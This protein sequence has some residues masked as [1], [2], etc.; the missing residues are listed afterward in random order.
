MSESIGITIIGEVLFDC[1]PDGKQIPGGAPFNVAWNLHAMGCRPKFISAVGTDALGRS[2][3]KLA[4]DWGIDTCGLQSL[5]DKETAMVDVTFLDGNPGFNIREDT[6][7]DHLTVPFLSEGDKEGILYHGSLVCRTRKIFETIGSLR[8]GWKGPVFVDINIR[9]PWFD[10][11]RFETLI[12]GV[13]YLK[14]NDSEYQELMGKAFSLEQ[15]H[16]CLEAF[17]QRYQIDNLIVTCGSSGSA[18]FDG[19]RVYRQQASDKLQ[20]SDTVGAGDTFSSVCLK[21]IAENWSV[22]KTMET[23]NRFAESVCALTG[24]TTSNRQFYRRL[25]GQ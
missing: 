17:S 14:L 8:Q 11:N 16:D 5:N 1:F 22:E 3:R 7:F 15:A 4:A 9:K 19:A 21:G 2:L 25:F 6:A 23:A 10:S 12:R 13:D 20:I 24:A 18:W